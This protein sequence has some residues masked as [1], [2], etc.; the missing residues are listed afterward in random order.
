MKKVGEKFIFQNIRLLVVP[1][2]GCE[3]CF[4]DTRPEFCDVPTVES[5]EI[6]ACTKGYR[7][8]GIPVIFVHQFMYGK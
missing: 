4:F 8:D 3:N 1:Q 6:L 5:A 2:E 7:D